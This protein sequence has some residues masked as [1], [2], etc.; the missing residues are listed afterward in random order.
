M[1]KDTSPLDPN[2]IPLRTKD[3][4]LINECKEN[5]AFAPPNMTWVTPA[6]IACL[7]KLF[8]WKH[9]RRQGGGVPAKFIQTNDSVLA[10]LMQRG[11]VQKTAHSYYRLTEAGRRIYELN[12][13]LN[14]HLNEAERQRIRDARDANQFREYGG[15][16][17]ASQ[18]APHGYRK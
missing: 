9:I 18:P 13:Y 10:P 12:Y 3:W 17:S 14:Q 16:V 2:P 11:A 15:S 8:D 6:Q 4:I 7:G 1:A 5:W